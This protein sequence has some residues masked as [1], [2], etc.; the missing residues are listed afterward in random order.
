M[1]TNRKELQNQYSQMFASS[2][3]N[4]EEL[5][6]TKKSLE[7]LSTKMKCS[8]SEQQQVIADQKKELDQLKRVKIRESAK[9]QVKGGRSSSP[10]S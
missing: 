2:K 8:K 7:Q 9:K 10:T 4:L 5:V 1:E 6:T 3:Q